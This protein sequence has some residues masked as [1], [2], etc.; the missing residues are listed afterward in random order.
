MCCCVWV[1]VCVVG[2]FRASPPD[3]SARPPKISLFFSLSHHSFFILFSLSFGLFRWIL[4]VF[5]RPEPCNVHIWAL[6]LS[7]ETPAAPPDRAA[8]ARTRQPENSKTCTFQGPGAS[9]TTKIHEK[10]PSGLVGHPCRNCDEPGP[11]WDRRCAWLAG[12]DWRKW[13]SWTE[14]ALCCQPWAHSPG[15]LSSTGGGLTPICKSTHPGR[16]TKNRLLQRTTHPSKQQAAESPW[17]VP[18]QEP[19]LDHVQSVRPGGP[20]RCGSHAGDPSLHPHGESGEATNHSHHPFVVHSLPGLARGQCSPGGGSGGPRIGGESARQPARERNLDNSGGVRWNMFWKEQEKQLAGSGLRPH[21][22]KP[23]QAR[24]HCWEQQDCWKQGTRQQLAGRLRVAPLQGSEPFESDMG[25][26]QCWSVHVRPRVKEPRV[27]D[28]ESGAVR[29]DG[30]PAAPL[31][32]QICED[33]AHCEAVKQVS[34]GCTAQNTWWV[35]SQMSSRPT[36]REWVMSPPSESP[37]TGIGWRRRPTVHHRISTPVHSECGGVHVVDN[38]GCYGNPQSITDR[39]IQWRC[40]TLSEPCS[41]LLNRAT[42]THTKRARRDNLQRSAQITARHKQ[43]TRTRSH[44]TRHSGWKWRTISDVRP[45]R[46]NNRPVMSLKSGLS[47]HTNWW[48]PTGVPSTLIP[49]R[50]T[51]SPDLRRRDARLVPWPI[52][53]VH[54]SS[55]IRTSHC[56]HVVRYA[57]K[58]SPSLNSACTATKAS[59]IAKLNRRGMNGSPCSP[60]SAWW[61]WWPDACSVLPCVPCCVGMGGPDRGVWVPVRHHSHNM[62]HAIGAGSR[63]QCE[64]EWGARGRAKG[65]AINLWN[66][67]PTW[68]PE[69]SKRAHFRAPALQNTIKIPRDNPQREKKRMNFAAGMGRKRAKFWAPHPSGPHP[70]GLPSGQNT[71]HQIKWPKSVWPKSVK[72]LQHKNWTQTAN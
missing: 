22:R 50:Q 67:A 49:S 30:T 23:G 61:I 1:W 31:H 21:T 48:I 12:H 72:T 55:A 57:N 17:T 20:T 16:P 14:D 42:R 3:P 66:F 8:G 70:S 36:T 41:H 2:V 64:L 18:E 62:P 68:Q 33:R 13:S 54:I 58:T 46:D 43:G 35:T 9:N 69:N 56:E 27:L 71:K 37:E 11:E 44:H 53:L 26:H 7:C 4:L 6:G 63:W 28:P 51:C 25:T 38:K 15:S 47:Q 65:F 52:P 40:N 59:W 34:C 10:T 39:P 32:P 60:P 45:K 29:G 5:W 24:Q 19:F